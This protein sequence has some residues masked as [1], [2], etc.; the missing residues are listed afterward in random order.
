MSKNTL[1]ALVFLAAIS[2][3]SP[4]E[5]IVRGG[6]LHLALQDDLRS[7]DPAIAYDIPSIGAMRL[8]YNGLLT[9]DKAGH[10]VGDLA[11]S[12]KVENHGKRYRFQLRS[13]VR[14]HDG[15][16]LSSQD[17]RYSLE[18]LLWPET[19]SQGAD[20]YRMIVGAEA[21]LSGKSK[22]LAGLKT[23]DAKTIEIELSE[24]NPAFLSLVA[25]SFT[26]VIPQGSG[27]QI[28]RHPIGTGPFKLGS[29]TPGQKVVWER[30]PHYFKVG[31][32]YL[33]R[34]EYQ[35]GLS[36]QV[37]SMKF[38]RGEIDI[39][40]IHRHIPAPD[41][42]YYRRTAR[43]R[44][45]LVSRPDNSVHY[46]GL[47]TEMK[48]MNNP[49]VRQAIS[50][51]INRKRLLRFVNARGVVATGI[52]PPGI[53]KNPALQD[54]YD[55]TAAK[56]LLKQAGYPNGFKVEYWCSNNPTTMRIVEAIQQDLSQVGINMTLRPMAFPSLLSGVGRRN[57]VTMF[58]GNWTADYP[59]P[60]NF[61]TSLF[62]SR[63]I[64][65]V[66]A[67]NTTFF[68]RPAV[69][70]LLD[71]ADRSLDAKKRLAL[72]QKAEQMVLA[73]A[74]VVPLYHPLNVD[75]YL[76]RVHGYA[77]HPIWPLDAE[78]IWVNP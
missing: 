22:H 77:V 40:G 15:R 43:F 48:P 2:A 7:L 63:N 13:G 3:A 36:E 57:T 25:L 26:S 45:Y 33:G 76:P 64:H 11:Q 68:K 31:K 72:Y 29:W 18:R 74:P 41:Y 59:D 1:T 75:I 56:A 66:N 46:I 73:E 44:P 14:F 69:D 28:A 52:L 71:A 49:K 9:Y 24:P 12:W 27:S 58:S 51:A 20:F 54:N 67:V 21:L 4:S 23:P 42:V 53:S 47:N 16:L 10:I 61:L 60:G 32:P 78:E 34:I 55:P 65:P 35:I 70:R 17:V 39:M 50:R 5:A 8:L 37:E 19:R 38:E 6:T 30:N 62:H